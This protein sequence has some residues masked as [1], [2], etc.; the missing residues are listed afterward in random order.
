MLTFADD[1]KVTVGKTSVGL[2]QIQG[3]GIYSS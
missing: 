2:V 3:R 1:A